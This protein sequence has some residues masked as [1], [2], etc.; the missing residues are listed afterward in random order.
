MVCL[1]NS[2][3]CVMFRSCLRVWQVLC[4]SNWCASRIALCRV[5]HCIVSR[6]ALRCAA[7]RIA[8]CRVAHCVVQRRALRCAASRIAEHRALLHTVRR[9]GQLWEKNDWQF[10]NPRI[11]TEANSSDMS[12]QCSAQVFKRA[13]CHLKGAHLAR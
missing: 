6:R 3:P 12:R 2:C 10:S 4:R 8:L 7:S 9:H 13:G 1:L 5:A 11:D